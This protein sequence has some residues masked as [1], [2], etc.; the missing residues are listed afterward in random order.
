MLGVEVRQLLRHHDQHE[1]QV[2]GAAGEVVGVGAGLRAADQMPG[3][4]DQHHRAPQE[5][6]RPQAARVCPV[7]VPVPLD[8]AGDV[9]HQREHHEPQLRLRAAARV[10][11]DERRI[12][13]DGGGAVEEVRVGALAAILG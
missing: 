1:A 13:R 2:A 4:V 3:L 6:R 9:L 12:R 8:R 10:E 7:R 5:Q 11:H